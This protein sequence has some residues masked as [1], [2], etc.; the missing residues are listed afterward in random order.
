MRNDPRQL[1]LFGAPAG[2]P[3]RPREKARLSPHKFFFAFQPPVDE[4]LAISRLAAT[5]ASQHDGVP[6][7]ADNLH[8]SL[9]GVGAYTNVP[10]D[11]V[12]RAITAAAAVDFAPF[13]VVFDR[14]LTWNNGPRRATVLRC[15][16]GEAEL[17]ALYTTICTAMMQSG[18]PAEEAPGTPHLTLFYG[19][20][21][22]PEQHLAQPFGWRVGRFCLIHSIHGT[23]RHKLRGEW[24]LRGTQ[25]ALDPD[26]PGTTHLL[27]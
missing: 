2:K 7:R 21:V 23:G 8:V 9:N 22:L 24:L 5:I 1:S 14:F 17:A 26:R 15:S 13:D 10:A 11:I 6:L 25:A 18:L 16:I 3:V 20:A 27:F 4:A 12:D 19:D